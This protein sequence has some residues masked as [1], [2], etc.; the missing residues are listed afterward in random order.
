MIRNGNC[1][2]LK[3]EGLFGFTGRSNAHPDRVPL[4]GLDMSQ[5]YLRMR[6]DLKFFWNAGSAGQ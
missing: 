1:N 3:A 6:G 4:F 5:S 2:H